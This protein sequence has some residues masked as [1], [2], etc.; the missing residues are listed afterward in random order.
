MRLADLARR[1]RRGLRRGRAGMDAPVALGIVAA[2]VPSVHATWTGRGEVYFDS[3][4]MFV[5][6]LLTARYLELC[7]RQA[8]GASALATPLV[9]R[10]HQA[11]GELGAAADRLAT[12]FV[13][14]QVALA[15][16]AGRPGRR[17]MPRTRC[18]SWWRCWS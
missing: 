16:A 4:T 7:A 1:R 3:V 12:R 11:G 10:L 15:L 13:F 9:R 8:C 18:R 5:A 6:F 17:S 14:V 2:F